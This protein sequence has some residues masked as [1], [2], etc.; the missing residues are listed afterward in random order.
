MY[1]RPK[2]QLGG[3]L[4]PI[5]SLLPS[6][7]RFEQGRGVGIVAKPLH[8]AFRAREGQGLWWAGEHPSNSRLEQG[9]GKGCGGQGN[10]P[11]TRVWSKGG[12][13][14]VVGRGTPLRLAFGAREG[15]GLWWAG[16][17]PSDLHF[18]RGRGKGC[19]GQG[20]TPPTR[21]WSEGG[22]RIVVGRGTP[23]R[24]AFPAREGQGLW[25]AGEHP[26]F[27]HFERGRGKGCGG[28]ESPLRLAFGA[29]EGCGHHHKY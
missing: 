4:G 17:H 10:T 23:L 15:Q 5:S 28:E 1:L 26:S 27:S 29:R 16:E 18:E 19:G 21:I 3:R 2:Q 22:A 24:L 25:W 13:R 8:L 12:A 14:V 9:R 7:L 20:N 11:P 6:N